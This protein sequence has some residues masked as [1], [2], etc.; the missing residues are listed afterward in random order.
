PS[1]GRRAPV[2]RGPVAAL[3]REPSQRQWTPPDTQ[4]AHARRR[5]A[6][7]HTVGTELFTGVYVRNVQLDQR[8]GQLLCSVAHRDGIVCQRRRVEYHRPARIGC[9]VQPT[10]QF[11][12]EV[13]LLHIH[14]DAEPGRCRRT[15]LDEPRVRGRAVHIRFAGSEPSQVRPVEHEHLHS[16]T[17]PLLV[18]SPATA[19][20]APA[21]SPGSGPSSLPG[22]ARPSSTTK[23]NVPERVFLSLRMFSN[24]CGNASGS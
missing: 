1:S 17:L 18:A 23:R 6:G 9:F 20:Y 22:W 13:A 8:G 11:T 21:S 12:L 2:L 10:D 4:A 24:S 16:S 7:E 15:G 14:F 5:D 19:E 3:P